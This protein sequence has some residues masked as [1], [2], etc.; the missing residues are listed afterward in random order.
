MP[1]RS[2]TN[3]NYTAVTPVENMASGDDRGRPIFRAGISSPEV[4]LMKLKAHCKKHKIEDG[5]LMEEI[6]LYLDDNANNWLM[7]LDEA[8]LAD[9]KKFTDQLLQRYSRTT[10]TFTAMQELKNMKQI[11]G[12]DPLQFVDDFANL[13]TKCKMD[14]Q[15]IVP[16]TVAALED[17]V[18]QYIRAQNPKS[19]HDVRTAI[20]R[21]SGS[22]TIGKSDTALQTDTAIRALCSRLDD[23][24]TQLA[25]VSAIQTQGQNQ[26]NH[27]RARPKTDSRQPQGQ[28][29]RD[30]NFCG[31]RFHSKL[32][33]CPARNKK[34]RNCGIMNHFEKV[35]RSKKE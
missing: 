22:A 34:C 29:K 27:S 15:Q 24:V 26:W 28:A 35:C 31:G 4:F 25:S 30:C 5:P 8:T 17:N 23:V 12:Q 18:G 32:S 11:K 13:Y 3:Y 6:S 20:T 2:G 10:D 19:L 33:E 7:S 16:F 21:Y 14:M 1:T 9:L